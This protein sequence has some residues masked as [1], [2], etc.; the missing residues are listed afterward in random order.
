MKIVMPVVALLLCFAPAN[1]FT[2]GR[3]SAEYAQSGGR[4]EYQELSWSPDGKRISFTAQRDNNWDIYVMRADGSQLTRLTDDPAND[5]YASWSPD[6]KKIAFA[7]RR[8]GKFDIYL[9][10]PTGSNLTR[11][12][13]E[14]GDNAFPSWSPDGKRIAFMSKRDGKWQIYTMKADGSSQ[15]R[16]IASSGNDYNPSWSPDG[17]RLVFESDR[18]GGDVD[19]IY[20][21]R[22]DGTEER[23]I[24]NNNA[25]GINDVFP[26]WFAKGRI[27]FSSVKN[28]R[29]DV[30]VAA[31]DGT[32]PTLLIERASYARWTRDRSKIAYISNVS[33][34]VPSQIYVMKADGSQL[35]QLTR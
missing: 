21:I 6:G 20:T 1:P 9:V 23:R 19:E 16:I 13:S 14:A 5:S 2:A 35:T 8:G 32:R 4:V 12:T 27:S 26:T 29:V 30:Y 31:E 33:R 10:E 15:R 3:P 25:E 34:D 24:T 11:L 18:D 28:R 17:S 22:A 7:S